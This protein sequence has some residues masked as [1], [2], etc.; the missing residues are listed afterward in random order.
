M[1]EWSGD[2][3]LRDPVCPVGVPEAR[4]RRMPLAKRRLAVGGPLVSGRD[5]AVKA[6]LVVAAEFAWQ[7]V[8]RDVCE[9]VLRAMPLRQLARRRSAGCARASGTSSRPATGIGLPLG[10]P[11]RASW[12]RFTRRSRSTATRLARRGSV[13]AA[14][15]GLADR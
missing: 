12:G 8:E 5:G 14:S 6:A 4:W 1:A 11:I 2:A 10:A 13:R 15:R 7:G 9:R 3:V